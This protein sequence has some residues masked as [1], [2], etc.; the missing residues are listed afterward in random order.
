MHPHAAAVVSD[1]AVIT[2][3][4]LEQRA[5]Q[6]ANY[7][8]DIGVRR[9]SIVAISL[10]RSF[11]SIISALATLK[12]GGA[13]LPLDSKIPFERLNF[14]MGDA[15]PRV[16]ITK[17]DEFG[18]VDSCS[19]KVI[20]LARDKEIYKYPTTA[21][22]VAITK[23]QLAYVIYTSGSSGQAKGVEITIANLLSLISW[24][25]AEFEITAAGRASHLAGL[26]FDAAV[27]EVWPYLTAGASLY[28]PEESTRLSPEWLR[29]WIVRNGITVSFLPTTLA[30]RAIALDWPRRTALRF[31]LTGADTLHRR[32]T[33][34]LPFE[35]VNNYGPTE[36]TVVAT[37]GRVA[38]GETTELPTIGR[39]I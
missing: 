23:D 39:P 35:L 26:A 34:Q 36:C 29:D 11:E 22:N 27:W 15:R 7:L 28:L 32:P 19:V 8:R 5:N 13:Y 14:V 25:Q 20:D 38:T 4:E 10:E 16:L 3:G 37:S 9:E 1:R 2:Y 31:L 17:D 33:E 6:L 21:P 18:R 30:E 12:A 24:H